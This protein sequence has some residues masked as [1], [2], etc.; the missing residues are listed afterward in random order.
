MFLRRP[1]GTPES[2]VKISFPTLKRGANKHCAY[3]AA[4]LTFLMQFSIIPTILLRIL[5]RTS[6]AQGKLKAMPFQNND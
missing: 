3:G 2:F 1:Y 6:A 5:R 4:A